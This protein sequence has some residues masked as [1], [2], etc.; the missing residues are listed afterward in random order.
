MIGLFSNES[1]WKAVLNDNSI[2]YK[3]RNAVSELFIPNKISYKKYLINQDCFNNRHSYS[4][5]YSHGSTY[6]MIYWAEHIE[7]YNLPLGYP[8]WF[9]YA[10][11]DVAT[12]AMSNEG[13]AILGPLFED[14]DDNDFVD[15][16][17]RMK[18]SI[19]KKMIDA[20]KSTTNKRLEVTD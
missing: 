19:M 5:K 12:W 15:S 14:I 13:R 20:Y 18:I 1:K 11:P 17:R 4:Y 9:Y 7:M 8:H 16:D 2:D 10:F 6:N 3:F